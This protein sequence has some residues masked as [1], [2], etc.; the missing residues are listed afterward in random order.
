M[1]Y[2]VTTTVSITTKQVMDQLCAAFEGGSNYW[3]MA[4]NPVA[5]AKELDATD[6]VVWWGHPEF[7]DGP[8]SFKIDFENPNEGPPYI[9]KTITPV[10]IAEGLALMAK[11]SPKHFA[12]LIADDGDAATADVFLQYVVLGEIV[13]G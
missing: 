9:D 7:F 10:E 11:S 4:A 6:K 5:S 12:T 8:F 1:E 3:V 13:F 2:T